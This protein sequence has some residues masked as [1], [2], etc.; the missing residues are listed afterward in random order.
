MDPQILRAGFGIGLLVCGLAIATL[1]FQPRD[2]AEFFVTVLA[3]LV[4][5]TL[6]VGIALMARA[7]VPRLPDAPKGKKGY[8]KRF[9]GRKE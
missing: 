7:A 9:A 2:S 8:N 4:G 1:P 6:V 3:A 5:G